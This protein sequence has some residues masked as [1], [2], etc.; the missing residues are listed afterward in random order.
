[1]LQRALNS[2]IAQSH[3]NW[4]AEVVNDD[5]TDRR[6]A[7]LVKKIA[8]QRVI[9]SK[10]EI[11]RGGSAN[12]NHA[13][14]NTEERFAT[15]LEDDN[16]Y[17][18]N[19]LEAMLKALVADETAAVAVANEKIWVEAADGSW[20]DT[21]KTIWPETSGIRRFSYQ[22]KD[23]CGSAKICNSS[24]LWRTCT[25]INWLTP[26]D[27]PVDVTEHFRERVIPHPILLINTPLVN[28]AQTLH[29]NRSG[30]NRVW[31]SYQALLISSVFVNLD[32]FTADKLADKL[33]L[34]ART[35]HPQYKTSL[36]H[37]GLSHPH[38]FVL[39]KKVTWKELIKYCLTWI[40]SPLTC[41]KIIHAPAL[42][43]GHFEFLVNSLK[44][45]QDSHLSGS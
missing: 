35:N 4:I 10:P 5:P 30:K 11:K 1:M 29:S 43:F 44:T 14:Q 18:P 16:W 45:Q 22:L 7:E 39:F 26:A 8:D 37:S 20:A 34:E 31:G 25:A 6:V 41:Y 12:F 36:L 38:A 15:I 13:F 27:V 23:K 21:H 28:F 40:R 9:L 33:W 17:E 32:N 19:F 42:L 2:V 3:A 24:M